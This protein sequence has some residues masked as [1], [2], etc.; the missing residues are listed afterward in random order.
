MTLSDSSKKDCFNSRNPVVVQVI[1]PETAITGFY[2]DPVR[3]WSYITR[4]SGV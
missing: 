2:I 1:T 4:L 3:R